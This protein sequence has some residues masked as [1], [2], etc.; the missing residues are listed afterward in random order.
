M[1]RDSA[2][3]YSNFIGIPYRLPEANA[4][5]LHC[6]ELVEQVM[7]S[8]FGVE[9]P[10]VVYSGSIRRVAPVFMKSLERWTQV[11]QEDREAGDMVLLSVAGHPA[12]CGILINKNEMLHTT[13]ETGSVI[14]RVCGIVWRQRIVGYYRWQKQERRKHG[15][16]C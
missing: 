16:S 11:D 13:K 6:W 1:I 10:E 5:G 15:D 4:E 3:D 8:V 12:H 2:P 7:I 9:P 14:E